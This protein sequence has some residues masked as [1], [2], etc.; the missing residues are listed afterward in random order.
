MAVLNGGED[1]LDSTDD[2]AAS[3]ADGCDK[4]RLQ[5]QMAIGLPR[6]RPMPVGSG[7]R[8]CSCPRSPPCDLA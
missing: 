8:I 2:M 5:D 1:T 6:P 4:R 3:E 7:G